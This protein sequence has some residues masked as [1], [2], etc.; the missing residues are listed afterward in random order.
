MSEQ[1]RQ[2]R[3]RLRITR[4]SEGQQASSGKRRQPWRNRRIEARTPGGRELGHHIAAVCHKEALARSDVANVFA[5]AVLQLAKPNAL[6]RFNVA[7]CS[8]IRQG[9]I[10]GALNRRAALNPYFLPAAS[11]WRNANIM[12]ASLLT[13]TPLM[14]A[15]RNVH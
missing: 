4:S 14:R 2:R 13:A 12:Y 10:G 6:H 11:G 15:G 8:Y 1:T 9:E 7:S 3:V 5:Q